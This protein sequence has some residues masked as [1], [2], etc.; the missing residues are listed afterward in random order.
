MKRSEAVAV[1]R[2]VSNPTAAEVRMAIDLVIR[3][4]GR[5]FTGSIEIHSQDGQPQVIKPYGHDKIAELD[6]LAAGEARGIGGEQGL[7]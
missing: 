6:A 1:L 4:Y 7:V 3:W 2:D 5:R